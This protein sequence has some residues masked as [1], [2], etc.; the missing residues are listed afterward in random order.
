MGIPVNISKIISETI[1]YIVN[2]VVQK[3]VIFKKAKRM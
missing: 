1:L 3:E 2:F